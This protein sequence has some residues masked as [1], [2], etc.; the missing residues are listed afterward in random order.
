MSFYKFLKQT[1]KKLFRRLTFCVG[2]KSPVRGYHIYLDD[3][4]SKEVVLMAKERY[5]FN[6]YTGGGSAGLDGWLLGQRMEDGQG[7]CREGDAQV[8]MMLLLCV[9]LV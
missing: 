8:N 3:R 1:T 2:S 5:R 6:K 4:W 9:V 7:T